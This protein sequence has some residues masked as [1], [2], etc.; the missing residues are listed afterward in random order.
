M[1][2]KIP[3]CDQRFGVFFAQKHADLMRRF[4]HNSSLDDKK[5]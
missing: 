2:D 4:L 3:N 5:K 1:S